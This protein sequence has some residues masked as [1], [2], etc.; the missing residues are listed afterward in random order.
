[1]ARRF[2]PKK[3]AGFSP[4]ERKARRRCLFFYPIR[5]WVRLYDSPSNLIFL[6]WCTVLSTIAVAMSGGAGDVFLNEVGHGGNG[7]RHT[8]GLGA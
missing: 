8:V 6:P 2:S 1:M 7:M 5:A 3:A 4:I